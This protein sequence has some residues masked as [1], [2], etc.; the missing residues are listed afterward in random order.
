MP[1]IA[2]GL[3]SSACAIRRVDARL[4]EEGIEQIL[5]RRLSGRSLVISTM[6]V[7]RSVGS[8]QAG[9]RTGGW[10]MFCTPCSTSG[11]SGRSDSGDDRLHPQ[12]LL[13]MRRAQQI[14]EHLERHRIDRLALDDRE[15]PDRRIVTIDVMGS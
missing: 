9:S 8:G 13:A 3:S 10:K 1:G 15:G 6:R 11:R 5:A 4:A 12:Q 2:S 7:R 14:D